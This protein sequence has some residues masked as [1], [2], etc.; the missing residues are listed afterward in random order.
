[1]HFALALSPTNISTPVSTPANSIFGLALFVLAVAAVIFTVVFSLLVFSVVRFRKRRDDDGREPPQIYG[2][3][4]VEFAR[5]VIPTLIVVT[6]FI[7][8]ARVIAGT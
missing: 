7:T 4:Q 5:T 2:S 6:L 3:N 1:M 8:T